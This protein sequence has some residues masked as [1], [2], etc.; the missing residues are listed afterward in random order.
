MPYAFKVTGTILFAS[1][2]FKKHRVSNAVSTEKEFTITFK[3]IMV[4]RLSFTLLLHSV[5]KKDQNNVNMLFII[6]KVHMICFNEIKCTVN[7]NFM[8][9]LFFFCLVHWAKCNPSVSYDQKKQ[10]SKRGFFFFFFKIAEQHSKQNLFKKHHLWGKNP[11]DEM[12]ENPCV[13]SFY[14]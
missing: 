10:K 5:A 11:N 1:R 9:S 8:H 4:G 14:F 12:A 13:K 3:M 2:A 7:R 6:Q